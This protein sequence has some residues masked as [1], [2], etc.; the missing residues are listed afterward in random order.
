MVAS[1]KAP[2]S[3]AAVALIII[4]LMGW[5][6]HTLKR[7][8]TALQGALVETKAS[9]LTL[10]GSVESQN[11]AVAVLERDTAAMHA[12]GIHA[13]EAAEKAMAAHQDAIAAIRHTPVTE[14]TPTEVQ[15]KIFYEVSAQ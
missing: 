11:Q 15:H 13:R 12:Q 14:C 3:I 10:T 5:H 1:I 4:G 2:L 8:L 7:D 9:V 6:G